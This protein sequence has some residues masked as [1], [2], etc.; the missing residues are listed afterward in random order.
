MIKEAE[1]ELQD[2]SLSLSLLQFDGKRITT[3]TTT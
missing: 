2:H 3:T 1:A